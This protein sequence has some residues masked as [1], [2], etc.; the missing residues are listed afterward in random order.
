[1][2][3][4]LPRGKILKTIVDR[5]ARLAK[6][7]TLR[8]EQQGRIVLSIT[9]S[10]STI[11]T[12]YTNMTPRFQA[13]LDEQIDGA[14]QATVKVDLRKL[15]TVLNI[16][17]LVY[18]SACFYVTDNNA[19]LLHVTLSPYEAGHV[20]YYVPIIEHDIFDGA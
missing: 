7:A 2:A 19:L 11:Q 6:F 4:E 18:D 14:N 3:L 13:P 10:S 1:M 17:Y 20:T 15:S 9:R 12:Y 8:A 16:H 5:M